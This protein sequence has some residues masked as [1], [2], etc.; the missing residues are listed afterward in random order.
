VSAR[1]LHACLLTVLGAGG[2]CSGAQVGLVMAAVGLLWREIGGQ[3]DVS[4]ACEHH[5][6]LFLVFLGALGPGGAAGTEGGA[7]YA[8]Q[9]AL[10]A[11]RGVNR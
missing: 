2:R 5:Q 8:L 1:S 11:V 4:G 10:V 9:S 6:A 7:C 3:E